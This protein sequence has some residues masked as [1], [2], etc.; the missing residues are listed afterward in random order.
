MIH[1]YCFLCHRRR[2]RLTPNQMPAVVMWAGSK[3]RHPSNYV[4]ARRYARA[5]HGKTSMG[6]IVSGRFVPGRTRIAA[7]QRGSLWIYSLV[8]LYPNAL[9]PV[10]TA[11]Q[12]VYI[13]GIPTSLRPLNMYPDALKLVKIFTGSACGYVSGRWECC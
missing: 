8:C 6:N 1:C 2:R 5:C 11:I 12:L 4:G 7:V 13:A 10:K 9:C 3:R